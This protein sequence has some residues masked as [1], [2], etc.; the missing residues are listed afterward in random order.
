MKNLLTPIYEDI[1]EKKYEAKPENLHKLK[2]QTLISSWSC[3]FDVGD[4]KK[5]AIRVFQEWMD[6]TEPDTDNP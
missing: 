6:K 2:L 4:C 5:K 1:S 3:S